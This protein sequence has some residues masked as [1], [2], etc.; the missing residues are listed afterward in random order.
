[1]QDT[2]DNRAGPDMRYALV[3]GGATIAVVSFL[4][5]VKTWAWA[6]SGSASVLASLVDSLMDVGVSAVNLMAIRLS[7]KPADDDHRYGHGK[8][9]G[10]AA[11]FQ[12]AFISGIAVFLLLESVSRFVNPRPVD[13]FWL[14]IS[15]MAVSMALSVVVVSIQKLCARRA[16]SLAVEADSAHY[17]SD[18]LVNGGTIVTLLA[19]KAG[20][21]GWIDPLFAL[22]VVVYLLF[23]V[24]EI[25]GRGLDMLM[26][27]ELPDTMREAVLAAILS[28][29]QALGVHDLRTRQIGMRPEI[30]F[31]V[32][33]DPEISLF[34]AH[35]AA[36]N[37][38]KDLLRLHPLAEI[39]IHMDPAGDVT[40]SRHPG[41]TSGERQ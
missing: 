39:M 23:T 9:E 20:A 6:E 30:S 37:I 11:L 12:S 7:L 1:M 4:V 29:P 27:R 13:A 24:R 17:T 21:P 32:E 40:D 10:L 15:V 3:A 36:K 33:M 35:E 14:A 5:L 16:P 38:E 2:Q 19:L 34:E 25:A 26:D 28:H 31:D 22:I 41:Q 8:V 18:I